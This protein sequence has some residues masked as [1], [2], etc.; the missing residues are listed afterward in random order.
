MI[1]QALGYPQSNDFGSARQRQTPATHI[2]AAVAP[3]THLP[4]RP[5]A[6]CTPCGSARAKMAMSL[7]SLA[8]VGGHAQACDKSTEFDQLR[9]H[10]LELK[11]KLAA[12]QS[13]RAQAEREAQQEKAEADKRQA[14]SRAVAKLAALKPWDRAAELATCAR[15][16]TK[17]PENQAPDIFLEAAGSDS[18]R[19]SLT[20]VWRLNRKPEDTKTALQGVP[21]RSAKCCDGT[22]S[23][24]CSCAG[25][26]RGCCARHRGVCGCE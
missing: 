7:I 13:A 3:F 8:L 25:P 24:S 5:P 19:R 26:L 21:G 1:T 20:E 22:V 11:A 17:C 23:P 9:K 16:E 4:L 14:H 15:G 10:E 18:E 6:N 2:H 12:D